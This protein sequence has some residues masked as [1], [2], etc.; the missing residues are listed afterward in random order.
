MQDHAQD[1]FAEVHRSNMSKLDKNGEAR[2]REDG[3]VIKSDRFFKP[4]LERILAEYLD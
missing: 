4:D 2:F 1:L 3:K